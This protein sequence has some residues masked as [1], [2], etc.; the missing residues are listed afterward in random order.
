MPLLLFFILAAPAAAK[1]EKEK[2]IPLKTLLKRARQAIKDKKDWRNHVVLLDSAFHQYDMT[3]EEQAEVHFTQAMLCLG[4]NEAENLKAYLKQKYDTV[5]YFS[6]LLDAT[7]YTLLC[8]SVDRLPNRKGRI[9]QRYASKSRSTMLQCR[10][11]LYVGARF[12]LRKGDYAKALPFLTR[13]VDMVGCDLLRSQDHLSSD[14]LMAKACLYATI[15]AYNTKQ[16]GKALHYIDR[17]IE[18]AEEAMRPK[19]Q[20]YKVRCYQELNDT[21]HWMDEV[22]DGCERY[23][24]HDYFFSSLISHFE[25]HQQ[26]DY[27]IELADTMLHR[28]QDIPLYWYAKSLMYLHKED[29]NNCIAMCDSTLVRDSLHAEALYNKGLS[30]FNDAL[31]FAETACYDLKRPQCRKDRAILLRKYAAARPTFERLRQLRPAEKQR[32]GA[33]LYRIYLNLNMGKEFDEMEQLLK[34]EIE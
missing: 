8:D 1:D 10:P 13:Y 9:A 5:V 28:V 20:E 22:Y 21:A 34:G 24:K 7:S 6:S 15:S 26:Y 29:W 30:Q 12:Y 32:W 17:A 14:T 3:N 18:G 4:Q 25:Q 19:L 33:P 23:P 27:G 31:E 11:N 2:Q 16:Y